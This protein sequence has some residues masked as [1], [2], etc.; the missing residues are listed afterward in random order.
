M[1][2]NL[3][4]TPSLAQPRVLSRRIRL[5]VIFGLQAIVFI[6]VTRPLFRNILVRAGESDAKSAVHLIA[7]ELAAL[8]E[9]PPDNLA[10]W[11]R[12][13]PLLQHRLA[14]VRIFDAHLEYHGYRILWK[15]TSQ[16]SLDQPQSRGTL[17]AIPVTPGKT[18]HTKFHIQVN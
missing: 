2:T 9:A 7:R 8:P 11:M 3:A 13:Q 15:P 4:P 14:D 10:L 17:W 1:Q 12:D 6:A 5:C 16:G 18:G